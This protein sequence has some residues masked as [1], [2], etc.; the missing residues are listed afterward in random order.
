[1]AGLA[2]PPG[3]LLVFSIRSYILTEEFPKFPNRSTLI[4]TS[5]VLAGVAV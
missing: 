3:P 4:P 1:M 5:C 2:Y